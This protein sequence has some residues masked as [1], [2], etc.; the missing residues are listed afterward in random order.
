MG[1]A[2]SLQLRHPLAGAVCLGCPDR[3]KLLHVGTTSMFLVYSEVFKGK[4]AA[5]LTGCAELLKPESNCSLPVRMAGIAGE[6]DCIT[7]RHLCE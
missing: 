7:R 5:L 6:A 1:G 4:L 3:H 2:R